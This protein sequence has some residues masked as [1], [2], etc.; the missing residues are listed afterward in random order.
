MAGNPA[1]INTTMAPSA[2]SEVRGERYWH[3]TCFF[4]NRM[5]ARTEP[6][7]VGF[8]RRPK[9]IELTEQAVEAVKNFRSE[10]GKNGAGLRIAIVGGGCSGF[11]Y[12]LSLVDKAAEN[13]EKYDFG[14]LPVFVDKNSLLYLKGTVVDYVNDIR[15]SGFVFQNPNAHSSC[16]CGHSFEA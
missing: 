7:A 8:A 6:R 12:D 2:I 16:G 14:G 3:P 11:Q 13:D 1:F 5:P 9:M 15:G 10:E 4:G